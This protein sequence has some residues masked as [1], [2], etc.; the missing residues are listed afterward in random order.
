MTFF[1]IR[2]KLI[3]ILVGLPLV[4]LLIFSLYFFSDIS[5]QAVQSFVSSTN[6]ELKHVNST[7]VFFMSGIKSTAKL[8][9]DAPEFHRAYGMLPNFTKTTETTSIPKQDLALPTKRALEVLE[10]TKKSSPFF[11]EAFLGSEK[12]GYLD[13]ELE[14]PG[15]YDPRKRDWYQMAFNAGTAAVTPAYLSTTGDAVVSIV[16]PVFYEDG[17][18]LGVAALDVSLKALSDAIKNMKIG[19]TGYVILVQDDGTILANPKWEEANFKKID[20]LNVPAFDT[21]AGMRDGHTE[22]VLNGEKYVATVFTSPELGYRFIG[23]ITKAEVMKEATA[24]IQ[25]LP[26][27]S[28]VLLIVFIGLAI[29]LTHTIVRPIDNAAAML[30]DIAQGEGDLTKRLDIEKEDEIGALANWFNV[31]IDKLQG[32]IKQLEVASCG[33]SDSSSSLELVSKSLQ[34]ASEA[35][36]RRSAKGKVG[37][38]EMNAS[39][40]SVASAM[41]QSTGNTTAVAT[42]AEEMDATIREIAANSEHA[43]EISASAVNETQDAS[44]Y[45]V[46]LG[47]AT[48]QIGS[49]TETITEISEQTNLLALNATIEA[50]RAGEAGKGFAVVANEIKALANQTA[51]AIL[52]IKHLIEAVQENTGK[53]GKGIKRIAN[54]I[55]NVNEIVDSIATAVNDQTNVTNDIAMNISQISEGIQDVNANVNQSSAASQNIL[56]TIEDASSVAEQIASSSRQVDDN[57]KSLSYSSHQLQAIVQNFKV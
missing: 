53:T 51:G 21:L 35:A 12:G 11:L 28:I 40:T 5:T 37:A 43:R 34:E 14:M 50:A 17:S 19:E 42:A 33:V 9:A 36:V 55:S 48:E 24:L 32:I 44:S 23:M 3:L 10:R 4:P 46:K 26:I 31:F 18:R 30:K 16:N 39:L 52:E 13:T 47:A 54:V 49:V 2:K 22:V 45:M 15:G 1:T 7:F 41:E 27:I 29:W 25:A 6:R 56:K 38:E 57:A 20:E 8:L